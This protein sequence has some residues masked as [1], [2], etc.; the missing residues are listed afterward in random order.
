MV[1]SIFM[2]RFIKIRRGDP[3][4]KIIA[5]LQKD[6]LDKAREILLSQ[7]YEALAMRRV[8]AACHVAVG[9]VYNYFPSKDMLVAQVILADWRTVLGRMDRL[10][11]APTPLDTLGSVFRELEG[12]YHQYSALWS[13]YTAA[14]HV[15]PITGAYHQQLVE[16]IETVIRSALAPFSPLCSPALPGFLAE[17]L[18]TA[19]GR[20]QSRFDQLSPIFVRL[21]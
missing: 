2:N 12:F 18:L 10:P 21:L 6:I 9:T 15:A 1:Y 20:G 13:E 7:G 3:M 19:A 14:G 8:A 16:Q 5:D 11:A 4:P 17:A